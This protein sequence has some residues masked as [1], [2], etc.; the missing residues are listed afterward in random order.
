MD[1]NGYVAGFGL[2]STAT[3][4][5]PTS[6]F[7]VNADK[8]AVVTGGGSVHPFTIGTVDGATR[9]IISNALIGDA[10]ISTAKI[11]NAQVNT[12]NIGA[13]AVTVPQFVY[14]ETPLTG[15][16]SYQT[17]AAVTIYA[18]Q[19]GYYLITFACKQ[20]YRSLSE[21]WAYFDVD[22]T[23][24][25]PTGGTS[26]T[27]SLCMVAATYL[28]AGT[29]TAQV[30]WRQGSNVDLKARTLYVQAAMR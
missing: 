6:E 5:V 19:A 11:G 15:N 30:L 1:A 28:S 21:W 16:G 2:A 23:H 8:F 22:G 14:S 26:G 13:N 25:F 18:S 24:L 17:A 20:D 10:S 7:I 4:G 27:D 12:L 29:H 9:T 3:N